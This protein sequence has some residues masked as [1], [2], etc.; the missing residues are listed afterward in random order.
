[1]AI[2]NLYIHSGFLATLAMTCDSKAFRQ[3]AVHFDNAHAQID[4]GKREQEDSTR[5]ILQNIIGVW[6]IVCM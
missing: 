4:A 6:T 5:E 1:M 2:Q 3:A